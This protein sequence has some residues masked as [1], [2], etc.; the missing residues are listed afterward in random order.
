[1]D[2][3]LEREEAIFFSGRKEPIKSEGRDNSFQEMK[4]TMNWKERK[5]FFIIEGTANEF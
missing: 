1:M 2:Y 5:I 4:W 3:E